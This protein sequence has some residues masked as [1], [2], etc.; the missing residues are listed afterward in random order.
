MRG[1]PALRPALRRVFWVVGA[2]F[3][4]LVLSPPLVNVNYWQ[5]EI[6]AALSQELGRRVQIGAVHVRFLDGPGLEIQNVVI[7]EDPRFGIEPFARI[8]SL[9]ATVPLQSLWQR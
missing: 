3:A 8:P 2:S 9:Q 4:F 5:D 1:L 7:G 6:I